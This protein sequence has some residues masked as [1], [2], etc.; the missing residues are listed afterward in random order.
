MKNS[1]RLPLTDVRIVDFGQQIAGPAVAMTLADLGATVVH[2]ESEKHVDPLRII[3][4]WK[5]GV[6]NVNTGDRKSVV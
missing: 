1:N 5:D 4:P 3:P 2:V 6:P